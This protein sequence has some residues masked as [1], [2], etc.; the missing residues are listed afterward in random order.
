MPQTL[1]PPPAIVDSERER[2]ATRYLE[3]RG[4]IRVGRH[5]QTGEG[6]WKP[7]ESGKKPEKKKVCEVPAEIGSDKML[8]VFQLHIPAKQWKRS[9]E[10]AVLLQM[11][12]EG[13][14]ISNYFDDSPEIPTPVPSQ[15]TPPEQ[16]PV[17]EVIEDDVPTPKESANVP[18]YMTPDQIAEQLK[19]VQ[20]KAKNGNG[21]KRE[22]KESDGFSD[23]A[24]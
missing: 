10:E 16:K 4:W 21:K 7:P 12:K 19:E 20:E 1:P 23:T 15:E 13:D 22:R 17:D 24:E 8:P 2:Q 6:I 3:S 5:A 18:K 9:T 11:E 14:K